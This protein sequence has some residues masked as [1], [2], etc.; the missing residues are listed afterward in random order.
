MNRLNIVYDSAVVYELFTGR[1]DDHYFSRCTS[2]IED[3]LSDL[4]S[5]DHDLQL[6]TDVV[7]Y[8]YSDV[9]GYPA[10]GPLNWV[11]NQT[12]VPAALGHVLLSIEGDVQAVI[13]EWR[14]DQDA[15]WLQEHV[16]KPHDGV[17]ETFE[18]TYRELP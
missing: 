10:S 2:I 16:D 6:D 3:Q 12:P 15:R 5:R 9:S 4:F 18:D 17:F 7:L 1:M 11:C 8:H 14:A 13:E